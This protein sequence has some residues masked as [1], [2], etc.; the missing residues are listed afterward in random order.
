MKTLV[1]VL[2]TCLLSTSN[3]DYPHRTTGKIVAR[4]VNRARRRFDTT[5]TRKLAGVAKDY[6]G[7][8][9][10]TPRAPSRLEGWEAE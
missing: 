6:S 5:I 9:V 8:F 3:A 2:L 7:G 10:G 4:S 1:E